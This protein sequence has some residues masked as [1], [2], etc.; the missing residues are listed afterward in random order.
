MAA[1]AET[2]MLIFLGEDERRSA[3]AR[4]GRLLERSICCVLVALIPLTAVPYGTVHEWWDSLLQCV[5]FALAALWSVEG[6]L[7]GRWL[8]REHR[9]LL[10]L[11]LLLGLVFLQTVALGRAQVAGVMAWRTLSADPY[12]TRLAAFRFLA[13]LLFA[14][15]LLRYTS[16]KRRLSALVYAVVGTGAGSALFGLVRQAAHHEGEGFLLPNLQPQLGYGQFINN[17][18]FALL[19]EMSLGLS[20]GLIAR[21]GAR[22]Q[23]RQL[24]LYLSAA[25][26]MWSAQVLSNSRG[27]LLGMMG[28]F[29][30]ICLLARAVRSRREHGAD[31]PGTQGRGISRRVA[32]YGL[33]ACVLFIV[34]AGA[35]WM[36]GEL[37][38]RRAENLQSEVGAEGAG[39]RTYPRRIEMWQATWQLIKEHPLVGS[40]FGGYWLAINRYY[41][42]S[43]VAVP[44]QAHND[45]LE[46][47]ASGGLVAA[48][49]AAWFAYALSMYARKRLRSRG[50]FRRA[51][52]FGALAGLCAVALHSLVDFGL[53]ITVN[54]LVLS[55]LVV[56][57]V[58]HVRPD[59]RAGAGV[60]VA[61]AHVLHA[62]NRGT[63][64]RAAR[65]C[66]VISCL[67]ICVAAV[68]AT[69]CAGLSRWHSASDAREYSLS[70]AERAVRLS[71]SDPVAHFFRARTLSDSGRD[72]EALEEFTN[73]VALR[74]Q[75]HVMWAYLGIARENS[76]DAP[77]ALATAQEAARLAPFYA[78]PHWTLGT[79]LLRAGQQQRAFAELSRAAASDPEFLPQTIGILWGGLGGDAGAMIQ[80]LSPQTP[81]ARLA[82]AHFFAEHDRLAEART[83]LSQA[84][85]IAAR[86]RLALTDRLTSA[87]KFREAYEVWSDG[88]EAGAKGGRGRDESVT[89]GSFEDDIHPD[90]PGFGWRVADGRGKFFVALDTK[91]PRDGARSLLL[92]FRGESAARSPIVS[93][94]ILVESNTRYRLSFAARTQELVTT[95]VPG[96]ELIDAGGNQQLMTPTLLP[97]GNSDWQDYTAEFVTGQSTSA[98]LLTVR[99][100]ECPLQPCLIFGRVWFDGFSLRKL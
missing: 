74:P 37:L 58:A 6:L 31:G 56:I 16:D 29:T 15:L 22:R 3:G 44:E 86:E 57:A 71:P 5:V 93:Q 78:Q 73:T 77:G 52:C 88:P 80:V 9:L 89:D 33:A 85:S 69:A 25:V 42:A 65:A 13:L 72:A 28:Q 21:G 59:S 11:V 55:A 38:I 35:F 18:H 91:E 24:L 36:G 19:M 14:A 26:F 70:S 53:H 84:G 68:W 4:V 61:P 40:G 87:K 50:S 92:D 8:V 51:A 39:N 7:S 66:A 49:L 62:R 79:A 48:A 10:P 75:D 1:Q 90:A 96:V 20:L 97:R 34:L 27:G 23:G 99:R 82:L 43:G 83:L 63:R 2:Q 81:A 32:R 30:F 76:G 100:Q 95:G 17:N 98:V 64:D 67:L 46:L 94:L 60:C 54:G 47:L 41:D 12:E 45:Y